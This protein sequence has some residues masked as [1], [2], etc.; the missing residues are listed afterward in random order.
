MDWVRNAAGDVFVA[1]LSVGIWIASL[2]G[3]WTLALGALAAGWRRGRRVAPA[4]RRATAACVAETLG[5]AGMVLLENP[6]RWSTRAWLLSLLPLAVAVAAVIVVC[7][8]GDEPASASRGDE[9]P[10]GRTP[11]RN[12]DPLPEFP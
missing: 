8:R 2:V 10:L 5:L 6:G 11:A 1:R 3:S 7:N 4:L 9:A 12:Q